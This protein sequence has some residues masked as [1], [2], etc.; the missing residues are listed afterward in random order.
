MKINYELRENNN[1]ENQLRDAR[2]NGLQEPRQGR[3]DP[4]GGVVLR[5]PTEQFLFLLPLTHSFIYIS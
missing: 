2:G 5:I 4:N 1:N 3:L